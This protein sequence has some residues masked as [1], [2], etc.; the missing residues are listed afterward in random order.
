MDDRG[1]VFDRM[2]S[3]KWFRLLKPQ[4]ESLAVSMAGVKLGDRLLVIGCGDPLLIAQLAVKTGLTGRACAVDAQSALTARA[5]S[6]AAREGALIET[7][8]APWCALPLDPDAFDVAVIRDVLPGLD[9][10]QRAAC[11]KEV[12]RVLRQGGRCLVIDSAPA[13]GLG[14][15]LKRTS[16]SPDYAAQGG[17]VGVLESAG[18]RAA[19]VLAERNGLTFAEAAKGN[20]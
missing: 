5:E 8:T 20:S 7:L 3:V 9:P 11:A 4:G 15:V 14:G 6:V 13:G 17:A 2:R 18:F 16:T 1:P 10:H 19:R 12:Q